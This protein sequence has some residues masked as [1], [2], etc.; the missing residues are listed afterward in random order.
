MSD[1]NIA[2]ITPD[3]AVR[4]STVKIREAV[5]LGPDK[6]SASSTELIMVAFATCD[7]QR[8]IPGSNQSSTEL[9]GRLDDRQREAVQR[10][11]TGQ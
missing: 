7:R 9:W 3:Q 10:Y 4:L 11:L 5:R 2:T 1:A 8:W 6:T